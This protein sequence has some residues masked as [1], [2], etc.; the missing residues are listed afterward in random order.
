MGVEHREGD[1]WSCTGHGPMTWGGLLHPPPAGG[2]GPSP[3]G[4]VGFPQEGAVAQ[5]SCGFVTQWS[6]L[7]K[8]TGNPFQ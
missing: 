6:I 8:E 7:E 1:A 2:S 4:W 5:R 3:L